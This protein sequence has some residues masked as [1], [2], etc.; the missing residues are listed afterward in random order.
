MRKLS[1]TG[2]KDFF[3]VWDPK[4]GGI[5]GYGGYQVFS[6]NGDDNYVITP[7]GGSY[8]TNGSISNTIASGAAFFVAGG[9]SNGSITFTES[10]KVTPVHSA[11]IDENMQTRL[12]ASLYGI[13]T[14]STGYMADGIMVNY[15]ESFSN[16]VDDNDAA[17]NNNSGENLSVKN[18]SSLLAVERRKMISTNDTVFLNLTNLKK[19]SYRFVLNAD[20]FPVL[21]TAALEDN[22]L[23]TST[24]LNMDEATE[25]G[26]DVNNDAASFAGNRFRIVF[27]PATVLPVTFTS[28]K[29]YRKLAK[30][31]VDWKVE[32]ELNISRYE[33]ERSADGIHFTK[34]A[35]TAAQA[36]NTGSASY[37]SV[38]DNPLKEVSYYRVKSIAK[39]G[40]FSY[41]GVVKIVPL[42]TAPGISVF[43]NPVEN[44]VINLQMTNLPQGSFHARLM[45]M[46]GRQV[47]SKTIQHSAGSSMEF[48]QLNNSLPKGSYQLEVI[49][50]ANEKTTVQVIL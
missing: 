5:Y 10:T 17:K 1:K 46:N 47:I 36:N 37:L 7:G 13:S 20:A 4:L 27:K 40:R 12:L 16:D 48:I 24:S 50:P 6:N 43:P 26:F 30:I 28:L 23:H 44:N 41:T 39:D 3:Y 32:N 45:D 29:V 33:T 31:N 22:Y 42:E 2:V 14:D 8:G 18:G 25:T 35:T 34:V 15:N 21:F 49:S 11:R 19:Q 38:D 9:A